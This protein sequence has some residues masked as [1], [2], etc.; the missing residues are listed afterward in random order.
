MMNQRIV[1]QYCLSYIQIDAYREGVIKNYT[2]SR[3]ASAFIFSPG[4]IFVLMSSYLC[5]VFY[6]W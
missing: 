5:G 1:A 2:P 4:V 6:V 3:I